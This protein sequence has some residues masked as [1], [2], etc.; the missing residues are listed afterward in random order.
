M[1][2]RIALIFEEDYLGS[3]PSFIESISLLA[4]NNHYVDIIGTTRKT[5]FPAPPCFAK[6]VNF[7]NLPLSSEINRDYPIEETSE[8][9]QTTTEKQK[10]N[11]FLKRLIPPS[12]KSTIR[13]QL[14]LIKLNLSQFETQKNLIFESLKY[15]GFVFSRLT[16]KKYDVVIGVDLGGGCAAYIS[17][18]FL[19]IDKLV[20]WGLEITTPYQSLINMRFLKFFEKK[21][22]KRSN[23]MLTTDMARANDV[24]KENDTSIEEK[25]VICLPHSPSGFCDVLKSDFFQKLFSLDNEKVIVL[26]SGWMHEVMQ[27]KN[28]ARAASKWPKKWK[29]IFHERMKR[30]PREPYIKDIMATGGENVLLSLNPVSYDKIDHVVASSK[31]GIVIYGHSEQWGSSWVSLAKGSGKIAHY[32]KCG[33]PVLCVNIPGLS[34][35]ITKYQCGILFD[36]LSEIQSG[37]SKILQNYSYYSRNALKCYKEEYEFS[38]YFNKF[39]DYI[40]H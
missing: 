36:E 8:E 9:K 20:Y 10:K 4:E 21:M 1:R 12:L 6:N 14:S 25:D 39:L 2:R 19:P 35:I 37:I 11:S 30:C 33:K 34:Q 38:N 24:C 3:Y 16:Q 26:H 32:L 29:L 5:N 22:C 15:T 27:S 13:N 31:I 18:L 28:L 23:L 7:Y 17:S 40:E